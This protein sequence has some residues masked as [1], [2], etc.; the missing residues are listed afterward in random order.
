MAKRSIWQ[1][2][3]RTHGFAGSYQ[4]VKRFFASFADRNI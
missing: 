4:A 1:A 3:Y 2:W